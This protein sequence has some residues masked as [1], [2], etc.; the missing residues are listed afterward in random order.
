MKKIIFNLS[1][2]IFLSLTIIVVIMTTI[3]IETD[4]FNNIISKWSDNG[5]V[6]TKSEFENYK[7]HYK[8]MD[9]LLVYL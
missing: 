4:K 3:G 8:T 7:E 9:L 6:D 1:A 2:I 5:G